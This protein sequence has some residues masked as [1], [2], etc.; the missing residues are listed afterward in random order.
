[1]S[2][3]ENKALVRR[4]ITAFETSDMETMR[5]LLSPDLVWKIAEVAN[6]MG[7]E[8]Y[9][10]EMS[11]WFQAFSKVT[12]SP[13]EFMAEDDKVIMITL[14]KGMHTGEFMGLAPTGKQVTYSNTALFH[15]ANG[16]IME[17]W[18]SNDIP[19]IMN[20]ITGS[21]KTNL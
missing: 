1:M 11:T 13:V 4:F 2:V 14:V 3:E 9:L 19:N 8:N 12:F 5:R 10:E 15:I 21:F 18:V 7:R 20:Q 17:V 6:L 16:L